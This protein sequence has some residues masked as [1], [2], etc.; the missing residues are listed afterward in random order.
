MTEERSIN[1]NTDQWKLLKNRK[2]KRLKKCVV[3]DL[4]NDIKES[5]ILGMF[6]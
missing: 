3:K 5:N 4:Q 2:K 6:Q 1:L